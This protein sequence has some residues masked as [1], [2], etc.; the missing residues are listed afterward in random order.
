[1]NGSLLQR[2]V[3]IVREMNYASRRVAELQASW[4]S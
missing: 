4:I 3:W 2:I 1:M